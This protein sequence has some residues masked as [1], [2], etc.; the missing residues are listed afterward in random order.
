MLVG[1]FEVE[2]GRA[3]AHQIGPFAAFEHEGMGAAAIEPDVENVGDAL[4]VL[5]PVVSPEVFLRAG[6][7]P[8][9][10]ARPRGW[11]RQSAR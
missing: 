9:I 1:A 6:I 3:I 7:G 4:V 10:D 8:G 2:V 5:A 11:P